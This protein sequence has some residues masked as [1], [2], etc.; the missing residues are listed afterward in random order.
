MNGNFLPCPCS[1]IDW[2]KFTS[3]VTT[4]GTAYP[5]TQ[6]RQNA[7]WNGVTRMQSGAAEALLTGGMSELLAEVKSTL[8][9]EEGHCSP[10]EKHGDHRN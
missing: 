10:F 8:M 3:A 7:A 5:V 2:T 9:N 1:R 6:L 4:T